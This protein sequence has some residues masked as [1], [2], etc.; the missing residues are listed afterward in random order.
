M[1]TFLPIPKKKM[2]SLLLEAKEL[3]KS[4][5]GVKALD[6]FSC[7]I[8]YREILGLIGPNGAG[9]TTFFNV[10]NGL[11]VPEEGDVC[12]KG[13]SILGMPSHSVATTGMARTFQEVRLIRQISVLDNVLLA[14]QN[15]LGESLFRAFISWRAVIKEESRR[16]K[17]AYPLLEMAGL[18]EKAHCLAG[19]LSYGQQKLLGLICCLASN[20]DLFLL[21]E[22]VAG[23]A[24]EMA[25]KVLEIIS[26]L[27]K[28]G[29]SVIL[30]EHNI[31]AV[32]DVCSRVIFMDAGYQVCEGAPEM[33][34]NNLKVI[35]AYLD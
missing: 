10:V 19:E 32:W 12:F 25:E 35:E 18:A 8:D 2:K 14:F 16:K 17:E 3:T 23:I 1:S 11:F 13:K 30:I 15:Q 5:D 22:P 21:D 31:G 7:A 6:K 4:F 9:K 24:P 33:V 29:K 20:A 34:R 27:P 28:K 26:D